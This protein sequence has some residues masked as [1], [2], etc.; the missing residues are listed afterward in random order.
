[1]DDVK[2][3]IEHIFLDESSEEVVMEVLV[4]L[5]VGYLDQI[6]DEFDSELH[7][8]VVRP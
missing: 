1:M 7:H 3:R 5:V 8:L 4:F 2:E 6:S